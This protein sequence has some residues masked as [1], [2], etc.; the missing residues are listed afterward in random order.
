MLP[1]VCVSSANDARNHHNLFCLWVE[2]LQTPGCLTGFYFE[3]GGS[4]GPLLRKNA[5]GLADGGKRLGIT[6]G[7]S[8][9]IPGYTVVASTG[10][11]S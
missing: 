8:L 5:L 1:L 4:P 7:N 9:L 2:R 6:N 10:H 11:H 3:S